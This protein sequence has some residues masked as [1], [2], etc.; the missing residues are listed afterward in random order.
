MTAHCGSKNDKGGK[1]KKALV[2]GI[3][4]ASLVVAFWLSRNDLASDFVRQGGLWGGLSLIFLIAFLDFVAFVP[5]TP[6]MILGGALLGFW[7]ALLCVLAGRMSGAVINY[8]LSQTYG[9]RVINKFASEK[10]TAWLEQALFQKINRG[11]LLLLRIA[12]PV[13]FGKVSYFAGL[14]SLR[15]FDYFV[16]TLVGAGLFAGVWIYFGTINP[17]ASVIGA[18]VLAALVA[19][20]YL[21]TIGLKKRNRSES[22]N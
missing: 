18:F 13:S 9:R 1:M 8:R 16:V 14:T 21:N 11:H 22:K 10:S 4:L 2:A 19:C 5:T 17:I 15:F 12:G 3:W 20:F 6:F 7:P